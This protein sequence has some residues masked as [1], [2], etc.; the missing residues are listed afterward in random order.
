[1]TGSPVPLAGRTARTIKTAIV[2]AVRE[3]LPG[4]LSDKPGKE[5]L[6]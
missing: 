5:R 3:G 4:G 1:M 2:R 6:G